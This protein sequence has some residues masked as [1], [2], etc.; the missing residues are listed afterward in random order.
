MLLILNDLRFA[1]VIGKSHEIAFKYHVFGVVTAASY[2][3]YL[4]TSIIVNNSRARV[5][6]S[7]RI[8]IFDCFLFECIGLSDAIDDLFVFI[9]ELLNLLFEVFK[10]SRQI[11]SFAAT[12]VDFFFLFIYHLLYKIH[13]DIDHKRY[14]HITS[15]SRSKEDQ[16]YYTF[17]IAYLI[18]PLCWVYNP[19]TNL[20]SP[21]A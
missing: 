20:M 5:C 11:C 6:L 3:I 21:L 16:N 1:G 13:I 14:H 15:I 4:I 2:R 8:L 12:D 18:L 9:F 17:R 7:S 10:L 19:L